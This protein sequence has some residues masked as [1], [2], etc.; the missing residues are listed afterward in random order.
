[1]R[2]ITVKIYRE[3]Q[4]TII[5]FNNFCENRANYEIMWGNKVQ[6]DRPQITV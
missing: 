2:D 1:M 3:N 6:P 4:T 5:T